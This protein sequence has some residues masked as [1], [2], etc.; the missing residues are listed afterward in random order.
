MIYIERKYTIM[1][2]PNSTVLHA[3]IVVPA[4]DLT[5]SY[6]P[7]P[8][9]KSTRRTIVAKKRVSQLGKQNMPNLSKIYFS[10]PS[11]NHSRLRRRERC[12]VNARTGASRRLAL[13]RRVVIGTTDP[14]DRIAKQATPLIGRHLFEV[15]S[16]V[17]SD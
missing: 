11:G 17:S 13:I 10:T 6:S 9:A 3:V 8:A 14:T 4:S 1:A 12:R 15:A 16:P 5:R 7:I 2:I